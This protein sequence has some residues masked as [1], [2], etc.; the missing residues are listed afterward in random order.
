[1]GPVRSMTGFGA[2][3][4]P[5]GTRSLGLELRSVNH[6][7]FE[8]KVRA[9]AMLGDAVPLV[10]EWLRKHAVRGRFDASL[11]IDGAASA[12]LDVTKLRAFAIELRALR[13][14]IAPGEP[15][16]WALVS[17]RA[18]LFGAEPRVDEAELRPAVEQACQRAF[19]ELD[20]LRLR[21]GGELAAE[22]G[23]LLD[24]LESEVDAISVAGPAIVRRQQ[25]RTSERVRELLAPEGARLPEERIAQEIA[26]LADRMDVTEEIARLRSH[27]GLFR[28]LLA[29]D[30]PVGRK[31]DF[32]V[33]EILRE[34]NTTGSKIPDATVAHRVV[35]MKTLV[36]RLREQ[37]ANVL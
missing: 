12:S 21:E 36:E 34:V 19:A 17:T 28:S 26:L 23:R 16:P 15:I 22:L 37:S 33:Q 29:S 8:A 7:H 27:L 24:E 14:E 4:A 5:L 9:P 2:A 20:R 32:V 35:Q 18:D 1:M 6:R 30:E 11:R 31:L 10:E 13:D 25:E 3:S